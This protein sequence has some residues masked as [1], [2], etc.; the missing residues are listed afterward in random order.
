[1]TSLK[2]FLREKG[3]TR[4]KLIRTKTNHFEMDARINGVDGT[5]ILDTGASST[6]I[7]ID[8]VEKFQLISEASDIKAAGAGASD[9]QTEISRKNSISIG[10]WTQKKIKIVLFDLAHVNQ[11]LINH[12]AKP[13]N[14]IIGADILKR[15]KAVIDYEKKALYLK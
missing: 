2:K 8:C 14:G 7:G 5:F 6:C 9:M 11:A 10:D 4:I 1:M 12:D 3:Y 15:G 13:V